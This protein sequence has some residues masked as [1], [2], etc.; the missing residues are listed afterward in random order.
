MTIA[1]HYF[2]G[3]WNYWNIRDGN[4]TFDAVHVFMARTEISVAS[5]AETRAC[6]RTWDRL[7]DLCFA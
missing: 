6:N 1:M 5:A 2:I 4:T 7:G 3:K